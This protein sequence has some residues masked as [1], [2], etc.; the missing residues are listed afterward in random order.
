MKVLGDV[1]DALVRGV[2]A[3]DVGGGSKKEW[4]T[5]V[6]LMK[7]APSLAAPPR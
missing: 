3:V 1:G 4:G 2:E 5:F 7:A 6:A